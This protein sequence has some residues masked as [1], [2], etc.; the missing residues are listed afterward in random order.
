MKKIIILLSILI[1]LMGF[2]MYVQYKIF[3]LREADKITYAYLFGGVSFTSSEGFDMDDIIRNSYIFIHKSGY[4]S[5]EDEYDITF[6]NR[7]RCRGFFGGE[8]FLSEELAMQIDDFVDKPIYL[9]E[10]TLVNGSIVLS[11]ITINSFILENI[12]D[13]K[14][15]CAFPYEKAMQDNK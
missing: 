11:K 15:A 13:F 3:D 1:G 5:E 9:E 6:I 12:D 7:D 4:V 8:V 14:K 2:Y 10:Y